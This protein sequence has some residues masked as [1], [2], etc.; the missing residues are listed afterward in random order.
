M[1]SGTHSPSLPTL[2][3]L[4]LL[5]WQC[6]PPWWPHTFCHTSAVHAGGP[7]TLVPYS[8]PMLPTLVAMP[9]APWWH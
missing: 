2:V 3:A 7:T 8:L 4:H 5:P 9:K 1:S 6:C